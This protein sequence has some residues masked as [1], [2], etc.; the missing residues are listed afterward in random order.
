MEV[1][2]NSGPEL[3]LDAQQVRQW[4]CARAGTRPP[5][6]PPAPRRGNRSTRDG[7]WLLRNHC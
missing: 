5:A 2:T 1:A 6:S 7:R 3:K 4:K